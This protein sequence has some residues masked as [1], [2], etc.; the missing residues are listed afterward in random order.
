MKSFVGEK[1]IYGFFILVLIMV[2]PPIVNLIS[3]YAKTH[4]FIFGWPTLLV[5]LNIWYVSAIIDFIA[6][7]L[8]IRSW[9]KEYGE[10]D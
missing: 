1:I 4:P 9:K 3:N 8:I 7:M 10:I 5:W 6:G 2:N